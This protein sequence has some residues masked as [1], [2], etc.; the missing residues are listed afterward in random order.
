M[1]AVCIVIAI[2][3]TVALVI[4]HAIKVCRTATIFLDHY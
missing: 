3:T 1:I 4:V 2:I